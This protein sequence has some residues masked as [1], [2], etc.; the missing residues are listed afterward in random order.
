[1]DTFFK[2]V[3]SAFLSILTALFSLFVPSSS[4]ARPSI[5]RLITKNNITCTTGQSLI[6]TGAAPVTV[7]CLVMSEISSAV[8]GFTLE[9]DT[10]NGYVIV[11]EGDTIADYRYCGF[12]SVTAS[13]FRLTITDCTEDKVSFNYIRLG[14][15]DAD[16]GAFKVTSYYVFNGDEQPLDLDKG[17]FRTTTD[18]I[19]FGA[20]DFDETGKITVRWGDKIR[21]FI[22]SVKE[23]A[24]NIRF[25][26]NLLGPA[27]EGKTWE[28][29]LKIRGDLYIQ[30]M[31]DNRE[32]LINGIV[33]LLDEYGF[34]GVYFDWEYPTASDQ[35]R[36]LS[37]FCVALKKALGNKELGMA[38]ASWCS[39]LTREAIR[40][41]NNVTIMCYDDFDAYGYHAAFPIAFRQIRQFLM[42]GFSKKQL[43]LG[44]AFYARPTD[45]G[46]YWFGYS[47][48]AETLGRYKN[49][50]KLTYA[51]VEF[52][53]Y[54][55]SCQMVRDKTE[56]AIADGLGGVMIWHLSCDVDYDNELSLYKEISRAIAVHS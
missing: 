41:I 8:K 37:Y 6:L 17:R 20:A 53:C 4:S 10:G 40:S 9:A 29:T 56:Y 43:L 36:E 45:R 55:N 19:I 15:N 48:A 54:F 44:L 46:A 34:S 1:M 38:M 31:R 35:K 14:M 5:D 47:D 16:A 50:C 25:H 23:I 7:N 42:N 32:T 21:E 49:L 27:D 33:S 11:T 28:E 30:A 22:R 24:P 2:R 18:L 26:I 51:G 12:D 13:S 3:F 52:E 39:T